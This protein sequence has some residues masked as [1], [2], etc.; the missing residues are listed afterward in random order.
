MEMARFSHLFITKVY[1]F[2]VMRES[3]IELAVEPLNRKIYYGLH[4]MTNKHTPKH[5]SL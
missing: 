1:E 4:V 3:S 2:R 5:Y